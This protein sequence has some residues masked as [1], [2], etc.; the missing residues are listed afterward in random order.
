ME[1]GI[2]MWH[3]GPMFFTE[4][5]ELRNWFEKNYKKKK[6][7]LIGYYKEESERKGI[8]LSQSVDQALCFGWIEGVRKSLDKEGYVI[9]FTPRKPK[10]AWSPE[11]IKKVEELLEKGLMK[12]E[13]IEV[14]NNRQGCDSDVF[15]FEKVEAKLDEFLEEKFKAN[16]KAWSFFNATAPSYKR[17][18][19]SWIMSSDQRNIREE[20]LDTLIRECEAEKML[21]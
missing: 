5:K 7:L 19:L 21:S 9:R 20:R 8:T 15:P 17:T 1:T 2:K 18:V 14:F 12:F 10:S 13:G 11:H 6:E 3:M 16:S 4:E